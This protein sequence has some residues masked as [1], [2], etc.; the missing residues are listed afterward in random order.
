MKVFARGISIVFMILGLII[1]LIGVS[2]A[3]S[4][5]IN[6]K[7]QTPSP[8]LLMP[9]LNGLAVFL[10]MIAEEQLVFKVSSWQQS[11]KHFGS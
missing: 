3:V 8:S 1:I 2:M 5:L 11:E 4:G 6:P 9:N 7:P 10:K